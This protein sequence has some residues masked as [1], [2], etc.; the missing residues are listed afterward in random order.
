MGAEPG[1]D[2]SGRF[3]CGE[4]H[5]GW[6]NGLSHTKE[7]AI[8]Y[9]QNWRNNNREKLKEYYPPEKKRES[10]RKYAE[11]SGETL[12]QKKRAYYHKNKIIILQN[13]KT[14]AGRYAEY[15]RGA[16]KRSIAF[17]IS[18]QEYMSFWDTNCHYC[19]GEN[20]THGIDRI[21]NSQGYEMQNIVACCVMCNWM[22][23]H[24]SVDDFINHCRKII[25]N[26][27]G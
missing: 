13:H 6:V 7:Y 12:K 16:K 27:G 20:T 22:K 18:F 10:Y 23:R 19:G 8:E 5:P 11:K 1:R 21:N 2:V 25:I 3:V 4:N 14:P 24:L 15:K 26:L 9:H 17:A